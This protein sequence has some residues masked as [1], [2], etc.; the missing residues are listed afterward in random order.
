M[1]NLVIVD[2]GSNSTRLSVNQ[3][4][5]GRPAKEIERMKQNTRISQGMGPLKVLQD[6][7]M[8]RVFS[9][10]TTFQQVYQQY[11]HRKVIGIATA[12]VRQ[13]RNQKA[14]LKQIKAKFGIDVK[15]LSGKQEAKYD[16]LA[17]PIKLRPRVI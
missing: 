3:I 10:L 11:D 4:Q 17:V 9:A 6:D 5:A 7:A 1:Q 12:A 15:V 16:Y 8:Q 14:F 2:L 13:A